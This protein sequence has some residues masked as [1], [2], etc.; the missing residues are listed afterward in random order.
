M[1]TREQ[2]GDSPEDRPEVVWNEERADRLRPN[3]FHVSYSREEVALQFGEG[4]RDGASED[5]V[6]EQRAQVVLSP[7]LAKRLAVRLARR[8]RDHERRFGP[9]DLTPPQRAETAPSRTIGR[10]ARRLESEDL[11]ETARR[12]VRAVRDLGVVHGLERSFKFLERTLLT[13]RLLTGFRRDAL[14]PD[15]PERL[16]DICRRSGMPADHLATLDE[17]LPEAAVVLLGFEQ[18]DAGSTVRAYLEFPPPRD[19]SGAPRFRRGP[20]TSHLGFKWDPADPGRK[21]VT[22]YTCHPGLSIEE[23]GERIDALYAGRE[24]EDQTAVVHGILEHAARKGPGDAFLYFEAEEEGNP[25][26]SFDLNLYAANLRMNDLTAFLSDLCL[27]YAVP[28]RD[29]HRHYE[30]VQDRIFGHLTGGLDRKG[31][32]FTT[33]YFG[34]KGTTL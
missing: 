14:P 7:V 18:D 32:D 11:P 24:A 21:A 28:Y 3:A 31:R 23:M 33:V 26:I 29:F 17:R 2:D 30:P 20:F 15:G 10:T 16:H 4:R 34:E 1:R 6:L 27:H 12:L 25:R 9:L 8:L 19:P 13:R 5:L 22:R